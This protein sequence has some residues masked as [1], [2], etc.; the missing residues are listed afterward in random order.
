MNIFNK[1]LMSF[2][3]AVLTLTA[4]MAMDPENPQKSCQGNRITQVNHQK[5]PLSFLSNYEEKQQFIDRATNNREYN[6][7]IIE[8]QTSAALLFALIVCQEEDKILTLLEKKAHFVKILKTNYNNYCFV[9]LAARHGLFNVI[10]YAGQ[11][12]KEIIYEKD[13]Q[14]NTPLHFAIM[15]GHL[16]IVKY[17]CENCEELIDEENRDGMTLLHLAARGGHLEIFKYLRESYKN[18]VFKNESLGRGSAFIAAASRGNLEVVKYLCENYKDLIFHK[19]VFGDTLLHVAVY[20]GHLEIVKYLCDNYKRLVFKRGMFDATPLHK[21]AGQ[22]HIETIKYLC[23]NYKELIP[24]KAERGSTALFDYINHLPSSDI[25]YDLKHPVYQIIIKMV[26]CYPAPLKATDRH[27]DL[28]EIAR[29]KNIISIQRFLEQL[30]TLAD[31]RLLPFENVESLPQASPVTVDCLMGV[32]TELLEACL[33]HLPINNT[34]VNDIIDKVVKTVKQ[35][36]DVDQPEKKHI[37]NI[38]NV[39]NRF[40]TQDLRTLTLCSI[41][42]KYLKGEITQED[43][44]NTYGTNL[45]NLKLSDLHPETTFYSSSWEEFMTKLQGEQ[46]K[47]VHVRI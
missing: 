3:V 41:R 18:L 16:E 30:V 37:M 19:H 42:T 7:V 17:L 8:K 2:I 35:L 23:E 28:I 29:D 25:M 47:K 24:L 33:A 46:K 1:N 36:G 32:E 45:M 26:V 15:G 43:I 14:N 34:C 38:A 10:K 20:N 9:H 12:F 4:T 11:K 44:M 22:G 27:M 5:S 13:T 31:H 40:L 6:H 21:V 39:Y